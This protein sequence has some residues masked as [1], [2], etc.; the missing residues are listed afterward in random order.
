MCLGQVTPYL[1]AAGGAAADVASG[2]TLTPA[3]IAAGLSMAGTAV[4]QYATA[5]QLKKQDSIA[6]EGIMK[7]GQ[8]QQQAERDVG[9]NIKSAAQ[10][11]ADVQKKTASQLSAYTK[12]IQAGSSAAGATNPSVPGAS[13]AFKEA[14]GQAVAGANKYVGDIASSAATTQ[15]TGLERVQEGERMAETATQLGDLSRQSNEQ[16]YVTKLQVQATQAN[17]WLKAAGTLLQG[18]GMGYGMYAGWAGAAGKAGSMASQETA[19]LDSAVQPGISATNAGIG[20]FASSAMNASTAAAQGSY[21]YP[22]LTRLTP[23]FGG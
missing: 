9:S 5:Q 3:L 12:A 7:Q 18:A 23:M 17:P 8:L 22:A 21:A 2:G 1:A 6:A 4:S 11:T 19:A 20:D 14:Q 13:K 10:S 16:N 15:G